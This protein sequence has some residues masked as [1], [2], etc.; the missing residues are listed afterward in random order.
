MTVPIPPVC[1]YTN[2][3]YQASFW[4]SGDREYENRVEAIALS[5]LLPQGGN[6]LL[7]IGAGAGRNT[8][9]YHGYERI[10]LLDYSATQLQQAQKILGNNDRFYY[11]VADAYRMP[12]VP[13][14][15]DAATMIRTLHHMANVPL[16]LQQVH[17]VSKPEAIFILEYANKKNI[18]AI[19]RF[20]CGKQ[21]WDPFTREAIEFAP[22][23][24][25]FHPSQVCDWL[26]ENGFVI[27]RQLT[28]SH[29][30]LPIL[31]R[32]FPLQ[33]LVTLDAVAQ[34]TGNFWQ[35]SPSV[36]LRAKAVGNSNVHVHDGFFACPNCSSPNLDQVR[37]GF[38]CNRC[39]HLWLFK[40]GIYYF[41]DI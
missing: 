37:D 33:L 4:D 18:K 15:F 17:K 24:Y 40:D 5:R 12:F 11:V 9:R 22:L 8:T 41:R 26:R 28:V 29:F 16:L 3:D 35:L 25:N 7:E 14:L 23:N 2:S 27:E 39:Q 1:D 34:Y 31:K 36:F 13:G 32:I 6:N 10:F 19:L 21:N 30:R 38:K 20:A